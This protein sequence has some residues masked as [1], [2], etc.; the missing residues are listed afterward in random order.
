MLIEFHK[1]FV[2]NFKIMNQIKHI[3][4]INMNNNNVLSE[5]DGH[6]KNG[7]ETLA[8]YLRTMN[9]VWRF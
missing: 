6:E 4:Y 2:A 1:K 9:P 8:P 5:K 3:I 7:S